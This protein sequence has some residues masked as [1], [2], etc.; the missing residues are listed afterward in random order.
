MSKVAQIEQEL[1][2]KPVLVF[3]CNSGGIPMAVYAL[4]NNPYKAASMKKTCA[5]NGWFTISMVNDW[6]TIL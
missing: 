1:G 6:T 5:E 2:Q 3:G 4:K